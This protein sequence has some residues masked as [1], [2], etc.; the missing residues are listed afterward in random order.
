M[1]KEELSV[2][3]Y[4][5]VGDKFYDEQCSSANPLRKWYHSSRFEAS[6]NL[7]KKYYK[8]GF[9]V[10]DLGCGTCNWNTEGIPV[11]GVDF[12][13]KMLK[14]AKSAERLSSY[15]VSGLEKVPLPSGE[16]DLVVATG[17]LEH[18]TAY[19]KAIAEIYRILKKKGKAV[20]EVPYDT[21]L[22]LWKWMFALQCFVQGY[23]LGSE[24]YKKQGGH[25]NHFSPKTIRKDFE[26]QGF[27]VV[28]EINHSYFA[29][30][31]VVEKP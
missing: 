2:E 31:L 8:K 28:E 30:F 12:N 10:A 23:L 20:I 1:Q 24:Y 21:N 22:S 15:K 19:K 14:Y 27:K 7:V 3:E 9:K 5:K 13:E 18:L 29:I 26:E 6:K 11:V 17:V 4:E 25:V 16:Y